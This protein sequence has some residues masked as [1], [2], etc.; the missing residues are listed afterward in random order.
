MS[1][2]QQMQQFEGELGQIPASILQILGVEIPEFVPPPI[3]DVTEPFI[4]AGV[5]RIVLVVIDNFGLFE[6]T[7]HKPEKIIS[8]SSALVLLSTKNPYTLGMFH[9][10]MYGGFEHEPNNFHLLR[11]LNQHRKATAFV[12]REK[13]LNR[14]DGGTKSFA[15]KED[16]KTWVEAARVINRHHLSILHFLDFEA[17]HRN[18]SLNSEQSENLMNKLINRTDKWIG[19]MIQ[20]LRERSMMII[21][22]N[23]GRYKIDLEYSGKIGQWR[24][25]SV[26][27]ALLIHK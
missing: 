9:Q 6:V 25:A 13:D 27:L 4:A 21:L 1:E 8:N 2:Q 19:T 12:G 18:R 15:K 5:D 22:G 14:Y 23:H 16:I 20:Q 7:Y 17:I 26:P 3:Y 11:Y 24:Q 10:V